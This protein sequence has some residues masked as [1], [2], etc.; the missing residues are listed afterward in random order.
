MKKRRGCCEVYWH[1]KC[2]PGF[3]LLIQFHGLHRRQE[4]HHDSGN[5]NEELALKSNDI[6]V[7]EFVWQKFNA[8]IFRYPKFP[9]ASIQKGA[10]QVVTFLALSSK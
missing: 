3:R 8:T 1:K 6:W 2:E 7:S 5:Y 10:G 4:G 9:T